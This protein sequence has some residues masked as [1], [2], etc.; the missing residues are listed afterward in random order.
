MRPCTA[1]R[2]MHFTGRI[3]LLFRCCSFRYPPNTTRSR[4]HASSQS[5]Q[6][7]SAAGYSTTSKIRYAPM[8]DP[9][10]GVQ[11]CDA[12]LISPH[13]YTTGRWLKQDRLQRDARRLDFDFAA[14]SAKA[15]TLCPR[16]RSIS[17][18]TKLEGGFNKAF[19]YTMDS[20]QRIVARIPTR[21]AGPRRLT[22]NSEV[23]TITYSKRLLFLVLIPS[24][25]TG[26][27][28]SSPRHPYQYPIYLTG[29]TTHQ[30]PLDANT[31]S[32]TTSPA[33]T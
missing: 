19:L 23:A 21:T 27:Q 18:C 12:H 1:L 5:C 29:A 3:R 20:G 33:L 6:V 15:I 32:W 28:Q 16:A 8:R 11:V 17:S 24:S 31:S 26:A 2:K 30:T 14:L 22:T 9:A 10:A 4:E 25:D 7:S 13:E